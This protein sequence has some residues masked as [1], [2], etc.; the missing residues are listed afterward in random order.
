M[1][2][3]STESVELDLLL[4]SILRVYGYDFRHYAR[5]SLKRRI[6]SFLEKKCVR[7]Y[8]ELQAILLHDRES[9]SQFL[10]EM[11]ITVTDMFR[12]PLFYQSFRQLVVPV[13]KTYPY[14]KIWHAGCAT[15]EEVYSLAI[16]LHEEG[17]L[18][19]STI[20]GTDFNATALSKAKSAIYGIDRLSNFASNYLQF[21]G[22]A[23]FSDYFITKYQSAKVQ[24]FLTK[25]VTFASHNL[26]TDNVFGEMNVIFCR[27]VLIYFNAE[28]QNRVL[29]LFCDSLCQL[30]YLCLG[31]GETI[32][33]STQSR[34]F[35]TVSKE[36][37]I[38]RKTSMGSS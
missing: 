37:K 23:N 28:L 32:N 20:Y 11:S 25:N 5:S 8:S 10:L 15:G 36:Y 3:E 7:N 34:N 35:E 1:S 16:L 30:G 31:A 22:E 26:V 18:E 9:F 17:M 4:E 6:K 38:Y 33:Y 21:G 2:L 29:D 24:N 19:R 12:D 13:L 27:N 14:L